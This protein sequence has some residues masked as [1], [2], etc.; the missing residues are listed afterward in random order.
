M[1]ETS[2]SR[3]DTS[4]SPAAWLGLIV[5][6]FAQALRGE[7]GSAAGVFV[8]TSFFWLTAL[9]IFVVTNTQAPGPPL[10][11]LNALSHIDPPFKVMPQVIYAV[12]CAL[13]LQIGA[14]LLGRRVASADEANDSIGG[15]S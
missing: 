15:Q 9:T 10:H 3:S 11:L 13:T 12:V 8:A 7:L 4:S 5:P 2:P 14:T 1:T 6:G